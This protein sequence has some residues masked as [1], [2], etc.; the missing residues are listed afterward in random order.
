M[1]LLIKNGRV[2]DPANKIDGKRDILI[3]KGIIVN[4]ARKI[5][6]P[7]AEIIDAAGKIVCPGFIDMH[8][9]IGRAHV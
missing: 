5:S 8:V 4:V 3:D 2:V 9:Q 7:G 6:N 1:K